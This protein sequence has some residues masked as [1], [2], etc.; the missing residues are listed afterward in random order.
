M[1]GSSAIDWALDRSVLPG[2]SSLGY[3]A[4]GLGGSSPDPAGRLRGKNVVVTGANSG[5]GAAAA[6]KLAALGASV[7]M[8]V[9]NPERGADALAR[10][11][12]VTGSDELY[13]HECDVS[14]RDSVRD[15]AAVLTD[16]LAA[17]HAL[18]HN[19]GVM[20]KGRSTSADGHEL[21]LATHVLG[22]LLLTDL[23]SPLLAAEESPR[24]VF[25]TS[26]GMYTERIDVEDLELRRR[27]FDGTA[28]YAHAK[29]AQ[30]ILASQLDARLDRRGISVHSMHPGWVDTPGI[31][32]ALPGFHKLTG[33]ILRSPAEG[34][35]TIV[36]LA[37]ADLPVADG[38][39]GQ[40]W[41]DRR[42]RPAHRVP[43]TRESAAERTRLWVRLS[44]MAGLSQ[45][46]VGAA[47]A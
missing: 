34:A 42:P 43:W 11:S 8:V 23:L 6:E 37:A 5:I 7:H 13:L 18:V 36:W 28:F 24:V 44:E 14:S 20:T 22:P 4:R 47:R 25:V 46:E 10:I 40:L 41:M 35:D 33:P 16:E 15:L 45:T 27:S 26:G 17:V 1:I 29:R 31:A 39:G 19:A 30:V 32:D 21:T 2:F 3:R 38:Q 12:E 9:R